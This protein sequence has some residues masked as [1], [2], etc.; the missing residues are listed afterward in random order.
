MEREGEGGERERS[1]EESKE[2]IKSQRKGGEEV[3][4]GKEAP[5]GREERGGERDKRERE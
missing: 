5:R 4:G 1:R 3:E 2:M